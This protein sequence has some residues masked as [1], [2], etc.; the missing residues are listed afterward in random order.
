M[1]IPI[2]VQVPEDRVTEF[3][4]RFGDFL[5]ARG[6]DDPGSKSALSNRMGQTVLPRLQEGEVPGWVTDPD[7]IDLAIQFWDG[8]TPRAR[9]LLDVLI[10]MANR[11]PD[12]RIEA[13]ALA[14]AVLD[15]GGV[16]GVAGTLGSLGRLANKIGIPRYRTGNG[17]NWHYIW[18]WDSEDR[19]YWMA[20]EVATRLKEAQTA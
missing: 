13:E 3:Y 16:S 11:D 14:E 6:N 17:Q 9:K 2:T 15:P 5:I 10:N 8:A 7:R 12:E 20:P 19:E 18:D 1:F 4:T